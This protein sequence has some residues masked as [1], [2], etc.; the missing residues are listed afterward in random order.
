[1]FERET[2]VVVFGYLLILAAFLYDE[3]G[4]KRTCHS[5]VAVSTKC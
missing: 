4:P 3:N 5:G 1:M 2:L